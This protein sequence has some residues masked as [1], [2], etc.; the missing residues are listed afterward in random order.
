MLTQLELR[1]FKCFER[2]VL[3]LAPLTLLSGS[4]ASGKSSGLQSL[5]LLH[6]TM[7]EHEWSTRLL[8]NGASLKLGTVLDVVDKIHGRRSF[9]VAVASA[10]GQV[11][12]L[13]NGCLLYTSDAA[14]E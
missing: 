3:P 9:E 5:V 10:A 8:L 2:L 11:G 14:D 1:H 7:R 6:Q 12:W 4:N 13:F